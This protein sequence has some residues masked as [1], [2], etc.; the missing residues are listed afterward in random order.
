MKKALKGVRGLVVAGGVVLASGS[1]QAYAAL[2]DGLEAKLQTVATDVT[3]IAVAVTVVVLAA[4][5]AKWMFRMIKS[6]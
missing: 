5:A 2:P 6:G 1:V 3:A 4:I